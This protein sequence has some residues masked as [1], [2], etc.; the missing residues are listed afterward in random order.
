VR[1]L[2]EACERRVTSCASGAV[3]VGDSGEQFRRKGVVVSWRLV[4]LAD[5]ARVRQVCR[6]SSPASPANVCSLL[7]SGDS[8]HRVLPRV[9]QACTPENMS[10]NRQSLL[11]LALDSSSSDDDEDMLMGTPQIL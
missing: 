11:D 9:C 3:S 6:A 1:A 2:L 4:F 5:G 7:E 8:V 10:H